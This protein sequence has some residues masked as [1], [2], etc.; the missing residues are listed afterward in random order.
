MLNRCDGPQVTEDEEVMAWWKEVQ[1]L[2]HPD[3][4][5]GWPEIRD[6]ASLG[7]VLVTFAWIASAHH[8]AINFSMYDFTAYMPNRSPIVRREMPQSDPEIAALR[9]NFEEEFL[10]YLG[11]PAATLAVLMSASIL[12]NHDD[13]E[14]YLTSDR[15][16]WIRVTSPALS[17]IACTCATLYTHLQKISQGAP[18]AKLGSGPRPTPTRT[19]M[20][21][22]LR[23]LV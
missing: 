9:E 11:S 12:T 10:S 17:P 1:V 22:N 13:N 2:G 4:P 23:V 6:I 8:A 19:H 18:F 7:D 15:H 3:Q 16:D 20:C 21:V 5:Q 14:T